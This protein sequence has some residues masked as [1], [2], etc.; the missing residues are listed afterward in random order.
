MSRFFIERP[1]F[2]AVIAIIIT[3]AGL[4]AS[5]VLP[6]A[7]YPEIAPP[8]VTILDALNRGPGVADATIFGARDYSMRIWLRPDRMAQLGVTTAEVAAALR[9]QNAQYAAGKVGQEPAPQG[10]ALV[11][12]VT[13]R[14]RL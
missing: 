7:Q 1:I 5:Q 11:Y 9:A 12:T 8:T 13:A 10:Q 6:V 14:G 2:A 4:I 3:L